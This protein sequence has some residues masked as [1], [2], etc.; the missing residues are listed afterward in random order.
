M[1]PAFH[2]AAAI[3]L[4]ITLLAPASLMASTK[5]LPV[6]S[7][8]KIAFL[9]DSITANGARK[10]GF[11]GMVIDALKQQGLEVTSIPA[12]KPGHKSTD[13]LGR[14]DSDV[15]SKSPQWM[16]LSCGVNDV[17]HFQLKMGDRSFEGVP[18]EDYKKHITEIVTRAQ[19]AN[20]KVMILTATM[21]SEDPK[22]ELNQMLIPYNDFLRQIAKERNCLLA[23]LNADMQ[24][25]LK[26]IPDRKGAAK[27]FG[28]LQDTRGIQNKLTVDGCHMNAEGNKMM[29]RGILRA[30]GMDEAELSK[31]EKSWG[32]AK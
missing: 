16:L 23:D 10:N 32:A 1:K 2:R 21:I 22:G 25:A 7:G 6:K 27:G 20:I 26:K 19:A 18:L 8:D 11:V 12:G 17:W 31:V 13:M 24:A 3:V 4:A 14:L 28:N 9:G 15:I 30:F 5:P 29:A